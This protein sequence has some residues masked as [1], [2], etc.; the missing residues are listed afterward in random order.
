VAVVP[1]LQE[2]VLKVQQRQAKLKAGDKAIRENWSTR[3]MMSTDSWPVV[4]G[5]DHS[6]AMVG[7]RTGRSRTVFVAEE[8]KWIE[9]TT[10]LV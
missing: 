1:S 6:T 5:H 9:Q 10:S 2:V 8:M 4:R 3:K 7:E